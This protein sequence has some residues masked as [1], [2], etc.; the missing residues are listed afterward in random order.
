[1]RDEQL[2]IFRYFGGSGHI[3][4]VRGLEDNRLFRLV[5]S[6]MAVRIAGIVRHFRRGVRRVRHDRHKNIRFL[7][8]GFSVCD[9][10]SAGR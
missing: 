4:R 2:R 10:S 7:T 9:D 1:M 8:A 5:D 3:G 6:K